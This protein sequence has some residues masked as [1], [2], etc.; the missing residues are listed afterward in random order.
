[1]VLR[2]PR[3]VAKIPVVLGDSASLLIRVGNT[4]WVH[5]RL[6][7]LTGEPARALLPRNIV[8]TALAPTIPPTPPADLIYDDIRL[9]PLDTVLYATPIGNGGGD[10]GLFQIDVSTLPQTTTLAPVVPPP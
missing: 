5:V 7:T 8:S 3:P 4:D 10:A 6:Y 9:P 2:V 1:M